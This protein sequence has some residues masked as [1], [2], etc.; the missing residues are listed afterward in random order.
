MTLSSSLS[1]ALSGLSAASRAIDVVSSNVA[2]AMT[3]GYAR[4]E[5]SLASRSVGSQ[6]AGVRVVGV[7]RIVN[8]RAL[9]DLRQANANTA[10]A[11][12]QAN[13]WLRIETAIG[14]PTEK[15]SL[16]DR[17]NRFEAALIAAASRPEESIRLEDAVSAAL[18]VTT[19]L[20]D[21]SGEVQRMRMDA[22]ADIAAMVQQVNSGLEQIQDLNWQIFRMGNADQDVAS[23]MDARQRAVDSISEI[24]PVRQVQRQGNQIALFTPGGATLIDG[25]A[26]ELAFEPRSMITAEM[27]LENGLLSGLALNG[28]P[29]TLH[30]TYGSVEG[31]R[32]AAAFEA[33]D[34]IAPEAQ[35]GLDALARNLIERFQ[36]P[37]LDPGITP[38]GRGLFTNGGL[39][40]DPSDPLAATG[41]ASRITLNADVDPAQGGAAWR[42]RDGVAAVA[43]GEVGASSLLT[44]LANRLAEPIAPTG[45]PSDG[46][47]RPVSGLAS[48]LLS[49]VDGAYRIHEASQAFHAARAD[50]L[51]YEIAADGVDTDDEM[52]KLLLIEQ[53]YA[54]NAQVIQTIDKLMRHL[55]EL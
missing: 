50:A 16:T 35:A 30:S 1:N 46:L 11:G 7:S 4:R 48:D 2:N 23:L 27:T 43:P 55:L 24:I 6:G 18:S 41:L 53:T 36:D 52:Q 54:A 19:A 21:I 12:A 34:R 13:A 51:G 45:G 25:P 49:S 39:P 14:Y 22:D 8:E 3:D 38:G 47:A 37:S 29:L 33:R 42:I 26:A 10:N 20:N 40:F 17:I 31:G 5:I 15:G 28:N 44:A 32:L 9:A